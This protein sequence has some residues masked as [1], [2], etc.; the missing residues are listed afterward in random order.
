MLKVLFI[1]ILG[2]ST[3]LFS[4][5]IIAET[6]DEQST[7]YFIGT[8]DLKATNEKYARNVGIKLIELNLDGHRNLEKIISDGLP[9]DDYEAAERIANERLEKLDPMVV[10]ESFQGIALTVQWGIQ[11][12][13]A[14]V[15]NEGQYVIYGVTD[16]EQALKRWEFFRMR[17]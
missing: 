16:V 6:K 17:Q 12:T 1:N 4:F 10:R 9:L 5:G 13:P 3:L 8:N 15:F 14:F 7:V 11:K 2:L